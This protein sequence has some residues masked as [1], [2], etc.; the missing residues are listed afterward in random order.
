MTDDIAVHSLAQ[1]TLWI[2]TADLM[3]EKSEALLQ[4]MELGEQLATD[5]GYLT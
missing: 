2:Q 4:I 1:I 3:T 5:L